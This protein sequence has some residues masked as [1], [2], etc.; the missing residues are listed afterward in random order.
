MPGD[1]V[2]LE[3]AARELGIAAPTLRRW[4]RAGAPQE[5]RGRRGRGGAALLDVRAISAWRASREGA[6]PPTELLR[7]LAAEIPELLALAAWE[8]FGETPDAHRRAVAGALSAF[9]Y[10]ASTALRDRIA[11]DAPDVPEVAT[12]PAQI[13]QLMRHFRPIR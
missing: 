8:V 11:S 2:P 10:R 3:D 6:V 13:D 7:V 1:P 4:L 9:W 5:R 12:V